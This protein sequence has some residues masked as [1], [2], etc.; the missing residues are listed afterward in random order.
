MNL[1]EFHNGLRILSSIDMHELV[2]AKVI[3]AEDEA[4]W[5]AFRG[6]PWKWMITADDEEAK[7]LWALMVARGAVKSEPATLAALKMASKAIEDCLEY[8]NHLHFDALATVNEAIAKAEG[9]A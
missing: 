4:E 6:N 5:K 2:E 7:A 8:R 9:S 1:A 3:E